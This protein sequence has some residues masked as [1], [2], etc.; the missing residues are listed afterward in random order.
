MSEYERLDDIERREQRDLK[1]QWL[2]GGAFAL[3]LVGAVV[4]FCVGP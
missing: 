3:I 1:W 4:A 2:W